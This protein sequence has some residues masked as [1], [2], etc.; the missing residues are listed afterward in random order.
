[1]VPFNTSVW[2]LHRAHAQPCSTDSVTWW[3][4]ASASTSTDCNLTFG[5]VSR[6]T[7]SRVQTSSSLRPSDIQGSSCRQVVVC[8]QNLPWYRGVHSRTWCITFVAQF[9]FVGAVKVKAVKALKACRATGSRPYIFHSPWETPDICRLFQKVLS[10][11]RLASRSSAELTSNPVNS[12]SL[13]ATRMY[14]CP[15]LDVRPLCILPPLFAQD[16]EIATLYISP[17]ARRQA[18]S[19]FFT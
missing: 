6:C 9:P 10:F 5:F 4:S 2:T 19:M 15:T 17:Q 8:T 11:A 16:Q 7:A 1:M 3:V 18:D 14:I 12:R 13:R